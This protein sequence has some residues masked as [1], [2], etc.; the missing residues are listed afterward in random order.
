MTIVYDGDGNRV[1][2][3][4]GGV[5]TKCLVSELNPTGYVQ[6]MDELVSGAVQRRYPWGLELISKLETGNS[7]LSFYSYDGHGSVRQLTNTA[8]AVSDTYTYDAFGNLIEQTGSTPNV[9]LYAGEQFDPDLNLYYNRARYL[10]VRQGRFWG[11]DVYEGD[12]ESPSSL[13][14]YLY[15]NNDPVDRID[16]SG[17][18]GLAEQSVVVSTSLTV[19]GLSAINST[20]L[21]G[22]VLG[23]TFGAFTGAVT[24]AAYDKNEDEIRY[25]T[26]S[27]AFWGTLIGAAGGYASAFRLARIVFQL[28]SYGFG[29]SA[30]VNAA[31]SGHPRLAVYYAVLTFGIPLLMRLGAGARSPQN[32]V[33]NTVTEEPVPTR[34]GA[35]PVLK[36]QAGV[37]RAVTE[38]ESQGGRILGR[39]IS[40]EADGVRTRLDILV[41]NP[42]GS[43]ELVEVKNGPFANLSPNQRTA[44][45]VIANEG[46]IPYGQNAADAGLTLGTSTGPIPVR[47]IWY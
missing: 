46:A 1:S 18:E 43:L 34:G 13:H 32:S 47:I 10:D 35:A 30:A 22:A 9:Y 29:G 14:K 6:V 4:G 27:G 11:M 24:A 38:I 37:N 39:E 17:L 2:K 8:G 7:K 25:A 12:P 26:S 5:T 42:D 31:R 44:I 20:A 16:R 23:G 36:G 3:S 19:F 40:L 15:A 28:V 33:E 41:Q 21:I 45:P